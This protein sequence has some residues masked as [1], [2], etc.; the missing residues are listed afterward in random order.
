M[1]RILLLK[2]AGTY[3]F[4]IASWQFM[5]RLLL[6][7]V[8]NLRTGKDNLIVNIN[9]YTKNLKLDTRVYNSE[10]AVC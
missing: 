1:D 10:N 2:A 8:S 6:S 4:C 7:Q 3:K 5:V 9:Y